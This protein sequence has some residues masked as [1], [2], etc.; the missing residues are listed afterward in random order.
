MAYTTINKSSEHFN[1]KLYTGNVSAGRSITGVGFKP[2]LVWNKIRSISGNH[3]WYDA[4]RGTQKF[5]R[6][7]DNTAEGTNG[8][9]DGITAFGTDGYTIGG[10]T[11]I[12]ANNETYTSWNWKANGAG[13]ANTD[14]SISSTV[15]A[16]TTAGFSIV[17]WTG[18]GSASTVGH[19]LGVAPK[20][21]I[22]KR[23][24]GAVND[25][26]VY[27]Q[28]VGNNKALFLNAINAP[29]TDSAYFNDTSPTSSVF[30]VKS[31]QTN[32]NGDNQI[33][34][35]FAQKQGYSKFGSYI[36]NGNVDGTFVYTGFKPAFVM[37]KETSNTGNWCMS[38]NK[39]D[40]YNPTKNLYA[41][42]SHA[43]NTAN[44]VDHCSNGFKIRSTGGSVNT[45]GSNHSYMAFAEAP[46]VGT[47]GVTA[48]AR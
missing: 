48:K 6:S 36:G 43:E 19:G 46:L 15:S 32:N 4:V 24:S 41:D 5:I 37:I 20:M 10:N 13:G 31:G 11:G 35:C 28:S 9:T 14:G 40:G 3:H 16:N 22:M 2:D 30:S 1:T 7:N 12:N 8:G 25:W 34:Y 47:N 29:D 23:T 45:S 26:V 38:D 18:T 33:A 21:I 39:R 42:V 44:T 17:K 27:H